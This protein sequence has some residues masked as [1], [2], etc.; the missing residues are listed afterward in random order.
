MSI[1]QTKNNA[2]RNYYLTG[3]TS[4]RNKGVADIIILGL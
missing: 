1:D 3:R 2:T 4:S